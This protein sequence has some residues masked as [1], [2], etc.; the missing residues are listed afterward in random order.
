V[1][2][3]SQAVF[4]LVLLGVQTGSFIRLGDS[5][6]RAV[7]AALAGGAVTFAVLNVGVLSSPL[8]AS[9]LAMTAGGLVAIPF[10]FKELKLLLR[11]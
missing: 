10:I 9:L 6:T 3:T 8:P 7:L 1:C 2:F 11:L 4:L 5:L